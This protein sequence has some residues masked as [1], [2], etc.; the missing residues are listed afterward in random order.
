MAIPEAAL[1]LAGFV[2]A[3]AAWSVSDA[4]ELLVSLAIVERSGQRE[5]MRFE[6]NTQEEAIAQGKA[7]MATPSADVDVWAF[8]R[9]G[10]FDEK[11]GKVDV[12]SVDIGAKGSAQRVTLVQRFEPYGKRH[13][14]RLLGDPEVVIDGHIQDS[15]KVKDLLASI[16]RGISQHSKVA[17]LWDSWHNP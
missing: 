16:R 15:A 6:A 4:P 2:L 10:L 3:H 1:L 12:I 5:V 11:G 14:F 8:A 17:P 7:K 13:H 9:E